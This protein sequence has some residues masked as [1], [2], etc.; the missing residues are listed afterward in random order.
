MIAHGSAVLSMRIFDYRL[1]MQKKSQQHLCTVLPY[2]ALAGGRC[3]DICTDVTYLKVVAFGMKPFYSPARSKGSKSPVNHP[4]N[5]MHTR[6][7]GACACAPVR[8]RLCVC[9]YARAFASRKFL[10]KNIMWLNFKGFIGE[11]IRIENIFDGLGNS[12]MSFHF[13]LRFLR[14]MYRWFC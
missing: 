3:N 14:F 4:W 7:R 8:V 1:I 10:Y 13:A 9:A 12:L 6:V 11:T 5:L 2:H